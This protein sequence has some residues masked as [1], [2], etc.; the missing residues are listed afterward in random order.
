V[1]A[2][3]EAPIYLS[4]EDDD[5]PW[6]QPGSTRRDCAPHRGDLLLLLGKIGILCGFASLCLGFAS[7]PGLGIAVLV[8][9]MA[10]HDLILMRVGLMD[11]AGMMNT[12]DALECGVAGALLSFAGFVIWGLLYFMAFYTRYALTVY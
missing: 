5:R 10:R 4:P 2:M 11:R 1:N 7:I 6:E 8:W 3:G 12:R 9:A